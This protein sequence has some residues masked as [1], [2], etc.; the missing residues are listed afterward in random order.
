[1]SHIVIG[2]G[3]AFIKL[4]NFMIAQMVLFGSEKIGELQMVAIIPG[5]IQVFV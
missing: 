5:E 2:I 4:L 3:N 1:M